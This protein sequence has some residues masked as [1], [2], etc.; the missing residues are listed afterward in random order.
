MCHRLLN[1][2]QDRTLPTAGCSSA[3]VALRGMSIELRLKKEY[4]DKFISPPEVEE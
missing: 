1:S 4:K 2:E 3:K